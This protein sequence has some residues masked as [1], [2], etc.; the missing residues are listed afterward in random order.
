MKKCLVPGFGIFALLLFLYSCIEPFSPP[1]VNSDASNLVVD[2]FLNIGKDTSKVALSR[3]QNTSVLAGAFKETG[4]KIT[5]EGET[6]EKYSFVE[7]G[8]GQYY[9]TSQNYIQTGKYRLRIKTKNGK[10]YLSDYVAAKKTP[11]IDSVT[12]EYDKVSDAIVIKVDTH[13][14]KNQTRFYRWKFEQTYEYRSALFSALERDFVNREI[15]IRKDNIQRCWKTFNSANITLGSTIKLTEDRIKDLPINVVPIYTNW[16]YVKYSILVKQY[17]LSQDA[18][19]Y[20]TSLAKTTQGTSGL[21]NPQP[22]QVTGNVKNVADVHELVFG[23]FSVLTEESKRVFI[24]ANL[25]TPP[26]CND[27]D[28]L[29]LIQGYKAPGELISYYG[30]PTDSVVVSSP[31]CADCRLQGGTTNMPSFWK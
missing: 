5:V 18:F 6:G 23:Y 7:K 21:F 19:E 20:W 8:G 9:L 25:G 13:D 31:S 30:W 14:P 26:R 1:E 27:L 11:A 17:A 16:F 10:E 12:W 29:T 3:T 24:E 28:T 2:G 15:I 4:A 22:S